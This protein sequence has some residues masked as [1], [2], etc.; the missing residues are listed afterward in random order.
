MV[1]TIPSGSTV[2]DVGSG[3]GLLASQ[4]IEAR[5]DLQIT[6][7]DVLVRPKSHIKIVSFDG[8]II[9]FEDGAFDVVMFNDVL[10]HTEDPGVLLREAARVARS[11]VVLKDHLREGLLANPTLRFMDWVGN[12][13]HGVALPYNYWT[14][15][16][17]VN[18]FADLQLSAVLWNED[19]RLYP[20][21]ADLFF[22][23]SLHFIARLEKNETN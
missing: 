11:S 9:P 6:G 15:E 21:V 23:R 10:H 5:P 12:A 18:A 8:N 17:W 7:I 1:K 16:Q 13:R 2:L 20:A 22:G 4:I 14:R 3:D 19:L